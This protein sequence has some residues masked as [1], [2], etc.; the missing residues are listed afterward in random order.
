MSR[1]ELLKFFDLVLEIFFTY[2]RRSFIFFHFVK[3]CFF[4]TLC[5]NFYI[6]LSLLLIEYD[7]PM[8]ENNCII[9]FGIFLFNIISHIFSELR[10]ILW[11]PLYGSQW[12]LIHK[13]SWYFVVCLI[14]TAAFTFVII[15]G[16]TCYIIHGTFTEWLDLF[17]VQFFAL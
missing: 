8:M 17:L 3:D 12:T 10:L 13:N 1:D 4:R 7:F 6:Y 14:F 11:S 2:K 9:D 16:N 15:K 5:D